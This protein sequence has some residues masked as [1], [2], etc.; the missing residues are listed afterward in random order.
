MITIGT[1]ELCRRT[2]ATYRQVTYWCSKGVITPVDEPNPGSGYKRKFD[3]TIVVKVRFLTEITRAF[4]SKLDHR[5]LKAILSTYEMGIAYFG[6][7][8]LT[9]AVK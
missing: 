1:V 6:P 3:E 8:Q 5:D 4:H 2:G 9:W 7:L